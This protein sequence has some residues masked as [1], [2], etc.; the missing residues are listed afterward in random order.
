MRPEIITESAIKIGDRIF[1]GARHWQCFRK[2]AFEVDNKKLERD[3]FDEIQGFLTDRG[4]FL[5]RE[6]AKPVAIE[7]GQCDPKHKGTLFSEDLW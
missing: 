5:T 6:E 1:T 4:R 7:A 2:I 3:E